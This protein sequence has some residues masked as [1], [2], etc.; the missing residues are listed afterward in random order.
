MSGIRGE[1][2]E[3]PARRSAKKEVSSCTW[4]SRA[5]RLTEKN[6]G[7]GD[8]NHENMV[9]TEEWYKPCEA[10][11]AETP[12]PICSR[13][14]VNIRRMPTANLMFAILTDWP[15][16]QGPVPA[17]P[18]TCPSKRTIAF[19]ALQSS[20]LSENLWYVS[21]GIGAEECRI[22]EATVRQ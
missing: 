22:C 8:Q 16:S 5:G 7:N 18:C 11:S 4:K 13:T 21:R 6:D 17:D 14:Q 12:L 10:V 9:I 19:V 15:H 3:Q 1:E 20:W 2:D